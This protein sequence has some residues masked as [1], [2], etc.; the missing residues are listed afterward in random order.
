MALDT[1]LSLV[2][3]THVSE[4]EFDLG[5]S[6]KMDDIQEIAD[7]VKRMDPPSSREQEVLTLLAE[8]KNNQDI[9]EILYISAHTVKN[10]IT[11]IFHKLDVSTG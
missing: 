8:G 4:V 11:K 7:A 6:S 1:F 3:T 10:H 2:R 9:A 5:G